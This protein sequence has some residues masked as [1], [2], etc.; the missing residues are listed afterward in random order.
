MKLNISQFKLTHCI[1]IEIYHGWSDAQCR[2]YFK[3]LQVDQ[4]EML[5]HSG[6]T[7]QKV[8]WWTDWGNKAMQWCRSLKGFFLG[9]SL[10]LL[11]T[12]SL[13]WRPGAV[14]FVQLC[15]QAWSEHELPPTSI[16]HYHGWSVVALSVLPPHTATG[17]YHCFSAVCMWIFICYGG[18][19]EFCVSAVTGVSF[20]WWCSA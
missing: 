11:Q 8:S 15:L 2:I 4:T 7:D 19:K 16:C 5:L 10:I 12:C 1:W 18:Q 20:L 6:R 3:Q 17:H 9:R 13:C 14:R